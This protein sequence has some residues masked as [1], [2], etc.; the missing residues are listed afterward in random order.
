MNL[1]Q[2]I[3]PDETTINSNTNIIQLYNNL[4]NYIHNVESIPFKNVRK[5][6]NTKTHEFI[7]FLDNLEDQ[8]IQ[9]IKKIYAFIKKQPTLPN[10][11]L[12]SDN[13]KP[14]FIPNYLPINRYIDTFEPKNFNF[15]HEEILSI[16]S[17]NLNNLKEGSFYKHKHKH[18]D[19]NNIIYITSITKDI[20]EDSFTKNI[21]EFILFSRDKIIGYAN[22]NDYKKVTNENSYICIDILYDIPNI[23]L[24][25]ECQTEDFIETKY[26]V[27]SAKILNTIN[28]ENVR[29]NQITA[30]FDIE[31]ALVSVIND[32]NQ[33]IIYENP[34]LLQHDY[35]MLMI[36]DGRPVTEK[37]INE[38]I[39]I[40]FD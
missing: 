21:I 18:E 7:K 25:H 4:N 12:F 13:T 34:L 31:E 26:M 37:Y 32:N 9:K 17:E 33:Y 36:N 5:Y 39:N 29:C 1:N 16:L 28:I 11:Y 8:P 22:S 38:I 10:N 19:N 27:G 2:F 24:Y 20:S 6:S 40:N 35:S 3:L 23:K 14:E 15:I 30:K